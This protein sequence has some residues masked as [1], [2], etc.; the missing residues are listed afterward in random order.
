MAKRHS[1]KPRDLYKK[2]SPQRELHKTP[3]FDTTELLRRS[4]DLRRRLNVRQEIFNDRR[5][6]NPI[7]T[8]PPV[9]RLDGRPAPITREPVPHTHKRSLI[10]RDAFPDP[11]RVAVCRR[12]KS[13]RIALFAKSLIGRGKGSGKKRHYNE[14]SK[15]RC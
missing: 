13:R 14:Y 3:K 11:V 4:K 7:S 8:I 1:K 15:V 5:R 10:D 9:H 12:R 2:S 6:F